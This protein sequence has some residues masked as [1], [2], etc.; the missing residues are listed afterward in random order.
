MFTWTRTLRLAFTL[1]ELLVVVAII[2]ILAAMLLPALAAARE[3]ARRSTCG[4][5]FGQIARAMESYAGD[6]NGY[7]PCWTGWGGPDKSWCRRG[8]V[9]VTDDTCDLYHGT[10]SGIQRY[11]WPIGSQF[12]GR[13]DDRVIGTSYVMHLSTRCFAFGSVPR[14]ADGQY[15]ANAGNLNA[16]PQGIGYL[17]TSGYVGDVGVFYCPS[18]DG[19]PADARVHSWPAHRIGHWRKLGGRDGNTLMYGQYQGSSHTDPENFC[20]YSSSYGRMPMAQS[21]YQYRN[22]QLGLM[23]PWHYY[24]EV[25][26]LKELPGTRPIVHVRSGQPYFRTQRELSGRALLADTFSKG[27]TYDANGVE[28]YG[29]YYWAPIDMSRLIAG[30]GL[31]GHVDGYN[32]L[33][34]DHHVA[35]YGDPQQKIIWHTQG[36]YADNSTAGTFYVSMMC[37]N[38][39][40]GNAFS[41]GRDVNHAYFR[42]T[43]N[44]VWHELDTFAD[45][46][47]VER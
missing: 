8:G 25:A 20:V 30:Y 31:R 26:G 10:G 18:S 45:I 6:Y 9:L 33:Y 41:T 4:N 15:R 39:F 1:I 42:N 5:N 43:P 22:T 38:Y 19:M 3:K 12:A 11:T 37:N 40:Y 47:V 24:Q 21:H 29:L 7:F 44:A 27:S 32:V 17:L 23:N 34:G 2:A 28:V 13:P 16:S 46:D 35:W 14:D 36:P